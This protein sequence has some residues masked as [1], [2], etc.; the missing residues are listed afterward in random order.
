V[1]GAWVILYLPAAVVVSI[2]FN[3]IGTCRESHAAPIPAN[4][5]TGAVIE[6]F[7]FAVVQQ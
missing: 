3:H 2:P 4:M 7:V 5:T 1:M 6:T